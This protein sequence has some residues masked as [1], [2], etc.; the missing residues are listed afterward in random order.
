M[1]T[2][3]R[4]LLVLE[5]DL[6][7]DLGFL[8]QRLLSTTASINSG[9]LTTA[10]N[11]LVALGIESGH[12]VL[13]GGRPIEVIER[14]SETELIISLLRARRTSPILVPPAASSTPAVIFT[15]APQ[16]AAAHD[17]LLAMLG[18]AR[19]GFAAPGEPDESRI[20][21]PDDLR[22]LETALAMQLVYA[23]AGALAGPASPQAARAAHYQR[24][25]SSIRA[26][27]R[28]RLDLNGDGV[29]DAERR[30][31]AGMFTRA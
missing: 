9:K 11:Q 14:I 25:A 31:A 16:I 7:R 27:V 23:A 26:I 29:A 18:L 10:S 15:F 8:A 22:G 24:V 19:A 20:I 6:F 3:D 4:D 5:P 1:F 12:V 21:N 30:A 13:F 17:A 2:A 28:A